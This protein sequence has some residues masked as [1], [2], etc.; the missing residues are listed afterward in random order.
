MPACQTKTQE[1]NNW[2]SATSASQNRRFQR[3]H[4]SGPLE[5]VVVVEVFLL[6]IVLLLLVV[7]AVEAVS[8]LSQPKEA[9]KAKCG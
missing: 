3:F 5:V 2:V 4:V 8:Y 6:F 9:A 1:V 7:V